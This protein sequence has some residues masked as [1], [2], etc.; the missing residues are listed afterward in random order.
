MQFSVLKR[1]VSSLLGSART[2]SRETGLAYWRGRAHKYGAQAVVNLGHAANQIDAVTLTQVDQIF[3]HLTRCLRGDERVVLD[4][5]CGPGRFTMHLAEAIQGRAV[6]LDP[7]PTINEL[8]PRWPGGDN[9]VSDGRRIPL[10]DADVDVVWVCL[11]LGGLSDALLAGTATELMRVLRPGGLLF[12]VEN[13]AA[14][15]NCSHWA[16]RTVSRYKQMFPYAPLAHLHDYDD[17]G[18]RISI[19]AGRKSVNTPVR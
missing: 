16:Y 5:G 10:P 17:L 6:G 2:P 15:A 11:V 13:T 1:F 7:I 8:A 19:M 18:E 14:K 3:P 4:F 12:L 9:Q